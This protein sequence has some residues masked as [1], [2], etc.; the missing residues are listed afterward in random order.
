M[1]TKP[2]SSNEIAQSPPEKRMVWVNLN[3]RVYHKEGERW[4]G[5]SKK[6]KFMSESDA[7]KAGF[8]AAKMEEL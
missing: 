7:Q 5:K 1:E 6:G 2:D 3:I 8:R 4:Y